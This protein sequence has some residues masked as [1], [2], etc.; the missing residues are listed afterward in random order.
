MPSPT[1]SCRKIPPTSMWPSRLP[2]GATFDRS[3]TSESRPLRISGGIGIGHIGSP[4]AVP[5]ACRSASRVVVVAHEPGRPLA[6]RDDLAAGQGRDVDDD[7]GVFLA[8]P[9]ERVAEHQ[10]ALGVGVEHL[11]PLAAVHGQH[12]GRPAGARPTACSRRSRASR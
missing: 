2:P 11:D 1:N 5:A 12:V 8:G 4:A 3:A 7:V 10:P 9:G 6:E